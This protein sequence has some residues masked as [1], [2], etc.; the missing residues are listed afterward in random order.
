MLEDGKVANVKFKI[1]SDNYS[2]E[3]TTN[4]NGEIEIKNL[5]VGTYTITEIVSDKYETQKSQ[6]VTVENGKTATVKFNNT[7]KKSEIKIIKKDAETKKT[8]PLSGF[9]FKIKK[10]DGSFVTADKKDV[11][12][13][14]IT[15]TITLPIKL[16]YGNISLLRFMQEQV[17]FLTA[18]L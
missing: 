11:F 8:I 18:H 1:T 10:S 7:L 13:T 17:M 2:E 5:K 4:S 15:G 16:T 12:Y 3:V 14:D 6:T 9:G